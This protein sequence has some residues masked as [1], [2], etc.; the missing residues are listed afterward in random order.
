MIYRYGDLMEIYISTEP[1]EEKWQK[2]YM[3][4]NSEP[5]I[6]PKHFGQ[7]VLVCRLNRSPSLLFLNMIVWNV[8]Y[9]VQY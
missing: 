3:S 7:N 8:I 1:R 6:C 5:Q 4:F 2:K 9:W